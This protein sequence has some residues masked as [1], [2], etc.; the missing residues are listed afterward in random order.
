MQLTRYLELHAFGQLP[1]GGEPVKLG[2]YGH[3]VRL[4]PPSSD[5]SSPLILLLLLQG[6]P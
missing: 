2:L 4:P 1:L 5:P 3:H 6:S